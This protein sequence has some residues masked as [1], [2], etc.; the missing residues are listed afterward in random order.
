MVFSRLFSEFFV[1]KGVN[2]H[3]IW[4]L[5]RFFLEITNDRLQVCVIFG[6]LSRE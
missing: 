6:F 2:R 5:G 1:F 4:F 3:W